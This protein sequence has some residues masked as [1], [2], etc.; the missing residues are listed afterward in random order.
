MDLDRKTEESR[1]NYN[2]K[3]GE[4]EQSF[5]GRFT[6]PYNEFIRSHV[7]LRDGDTILDV[8][9]GNGRL[10]NMLAGTARVS[11]Y[12]IDVSE[13]MVRVAAVENPQLRFVVG[14]ADQMPFD[15]GMFDLVTVCCAFHHF[16]RPQKFMAE[17]FRILKPG[18]RLLIAEPCPPP[19]VRGLENLLLPFFRMGDVKIY[20]QKRLADFY[21][22][23][24][25]H[26]ISFIRQ[27]SQL[28]ISG[29]KP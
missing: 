17:S 4:Y 22:G 8:A 9:C 19:L 12:G 14:T 26:E 18:G 11:G 16:T 13:E 5:E 2:R 20:S 29:I 25:F 3:A 7:R 1:Q 28:Y 23:A 15:D 27:G 10:L 6:L 24:G 21:T